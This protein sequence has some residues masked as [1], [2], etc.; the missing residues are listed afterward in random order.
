MPDIGD[1]RTLLA[2]I[3]SLGVDVSFEKGIVRLDTSKMTMASLD[4]ALIRK[5]RVGIMLIPAL[6]ARFSDVKMPYPGGCNIGK[7]GIEEHL[8]G[9]RSMGYQ[10]DFDGENIHIFGQAKSG[11]IECVPYFSVTATENMI[12]ANA[13]RNGSTTI[14]IAAIEP[15]VVNLIES[16][17]SMGAKIHLNY[18][19]TITIE[20]QSLDTE[21]TFRANIIHD[22]IESGTF[23]VFGALA[24]KDFIDIK[25]ARIKDLSSFLEKCREVGVRFEN[26]GGDTLRVYRSEDL[27]A[28]KF[29]TNVFPGFPTDLQSIFGVLLTQAD[30]ISR[31]QE[32]MFEGRLNFLVEIEKMK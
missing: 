31:V 23:V 9:F 4:Y 1:I 10:V 16:L 24:S 13:W 12:M 11:E 26:L 6:L 14:R 5:I 32:I 22:Y 29:Q 27:K 20:G 21:Q 15:H 19:H 25:N 30:G 28:V 7:R 17:E 2:I 18:D 3:A 8:Q